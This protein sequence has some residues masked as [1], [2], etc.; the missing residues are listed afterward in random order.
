MAGLIA[1]SYLP[2]KPALDLEPK[3][4]SALPTCGLALCAVF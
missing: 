1:Y 4:L 2:H 3:A